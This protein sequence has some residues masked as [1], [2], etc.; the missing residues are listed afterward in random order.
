MSST[1][2][3]CD[4]PS[5]LRKSSVPA[6]LT[7]TL[8]PCGPKYPMSA[9]SSAME[10]TSKRGGVA[11]ASCSES[12]RRRIAIG[13]SSSSRFSGRGST[14]SGVVGSGTISVSSA[15]GVLSPP[16]WMATAIVPA[17]TASRPIDATARVHRDQVFRRRG[18]PPTGSKSRWRDAEQPLDPE[19]IDPPCAHGSGPPVR[20]V[21][22]I[23]PP[24]QT[25]RCR[26]MQ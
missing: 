16:E 20:S 9:S 18:A 15:V 8:V 6:S 14:V 4:P 2:T 13:D 22:A 5:G 7:T 24:L 3:S 11:P 1:P 23:P 19:D 10:M 26:T 25:L 17:A 12:G 21:P